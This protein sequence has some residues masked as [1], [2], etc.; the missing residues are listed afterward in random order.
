[1]PAFEVLS[2][3]PKGLPNDMLAM[4]WCPTMD[5]LALIMSD[6]QILVHRVTWQRLFAISCVDEPPVRCLAWRPDGKHLAAG[7]ADGSVTI[8]D[9]ENGEQLSRHREHPSALFLFSWVAAAA[10]EPGARESPYVSSMEG[11]FAPLPQLPKQATAQ[12]LLMEEG[13]PQLD[14]TLHQLLFDACSTLDFDV[15]VTA[16]ADARVHLA[17]HGRFSLGSLHLAELPALQFGGGSP[18]QLLAV[19]LASTLHALTVVLRTSAET[20]VMLPDGTR[21][22]HEPGVLLLS[23]RTGQLARSR[24]EIGALALACLQCDALA[25]RAYA[26]VATAERVWRE[27]IEPLHQKLAKMG[28]VLRENGR[29]STP[30]VEL[31]MLLASGVPPSCVQAFLLRELNGEALQ[32]LLKAVGVAS[33]ALTQLCVCHLAPACEMLIQRLGHLHGLSR[34]PFHFVALGLQ[35]QRVNAALEAAV[36]LRASAELLQVNVHKARAEFGML[37]CW[38]VRIHRRLRD[39]PPPA[40]EEIP[41]LNTAALCAMLKH[42]AQRG[43]LPVDPVLDLFSDDTGPIESCAPDALDELAALPPTLRLPAAQQQLTTAL[44][45]CFQPVAHHVS[46]GI[47]LHSCSALCAGAAAADGRIEVELRHVEPPPPPPPPAAGSALAAG[48][49]REASA[50]TL[51]LSVVARDDDDG[52]ARLLLLRAR[53]GLQDSDAPAWEAADV[54]AA[55]DLQ[56]QR[57]LSCHFYKE[58]MLALLHAGEEPGATSLTVTPHAALQYSPLVGGGAGGGGAAAGSGATLLARVAEL[59]SSG[60]LTVQ[61]LDEGRKR[62]FGGMS[63]VQ[64]ALSQQRGVACLVGARRR[65]LLL[66]VE[67]DEESDEEGDDDDDDDITEGGPSPAGGGG[68]TDEDEDMAMDDNDDE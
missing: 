31:I 66:D 26:A 10:A 48:V 63:A 36:S 62:V 32:R 57:L 65:V 33:S 34:W 21:Q 16:D 43:G 2:G 35:P 12:Q 49:E 59:V 68:A 27:A 47:Q 8:Y 38:L 28:D 30:A 4:E 56:G 29:Q 44:A 15:A 5:L 50:P 42:A 51:L 41:P 9:V 60:A 18:P 37:M 11:L 58:D 23:F 22:Q 53:W 14:V 54:R 19:Q 7:H 61:T 13:V 25:Q 3:F 40:A 17:V 24:Q 67:E 39:E 20:S 55:D 64:L 1:M 46:S 52:R 45:D 6:S